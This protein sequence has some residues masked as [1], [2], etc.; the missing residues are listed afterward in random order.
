MKVIYSEK[1]DKKKKSNTVQ[2]KNLD[3]SLIMLL[4]VL[5]FFFLTIFTNY[6]KE[7][8]I[9]SDKRK[10]DYLNFLFDN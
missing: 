3:A 9:L 2:P 6:R 10:I 5:L 1:K 7:N 8:D 4:L